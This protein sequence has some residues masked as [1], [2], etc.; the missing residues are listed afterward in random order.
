MGIFYCAHGNSGLGLGPVFMSPLGRFK[1]NITLEVGLDFG[2]CLGV[3]LSVISN[4]CEI[5][6]PFLKVI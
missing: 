2:W 1:N 6:D 5:R 4:T 3:N